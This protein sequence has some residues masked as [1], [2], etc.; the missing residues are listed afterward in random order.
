MAASSE[1]LRH[2]A[3]LPTSREAE[4]GD[5]PDAPQRGGAIVSLSVVTVSGDVLAD[6]HELSRTTLLYEICA[7]WQQMVTSEGETLSLTCSLGEVAGACDAIT[8]TSVCMSFPSWNGACEVGDE[9]LKRAYIRGVFA[10][11]NDC[12]DV[13]FAGRALQVATELYMCEGDGRVFLGYLRALYELAS[14]GGCWLDPLRPLVQDL[15]RAFC[16]NQCKANS[17]QRCFL[18][19]FVLEYVYKKLQLFKKLCFPA[20]AGRDEGRL[21]LQLFADRL[22]HGPNSESVIRDAAENKPWVRATTNR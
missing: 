2:E 17:V 9:Q 19:G 22:T 14:P 8:L 13:A 21:L 15:H 11:L 16:T 12:R 18:E 1:T 7:P 4:E 20:K 5:T 6:A 3:P 10:H